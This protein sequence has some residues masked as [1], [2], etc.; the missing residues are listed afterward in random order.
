MLKKIVDYKRFELESRR[1]LVPYFELEKRTKGL[2]PGGSS[3]SRALVAP[4]VSI[5]AEIKYKSPSH[6]PFSCRM[7]PELIAE[8]YLRAGASAISVLTDE[9]FFSGKLDFL[10]RVRKHLDVIDQEEEI[11]VLRK[12]FIFDRYQVLEASLVGASALLLI[13]AIL[14]P[15]ELRSLLSF[16]R[17]KGLEVLVEVHSP[18]E[19]EI[20]LESGAEIIGVNNRNLETFEVDLRTSF[21]IARRLEGVK[22]QV[23]VAESGIS[24]AVQLSE[25]SDAGFD[26]FLVGSAFMDS[27]RPGEALAKLLSGL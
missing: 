19:L 27:P 12:D 10:A 4:G 1:N 5:I 2:R 15:S 25:L 13:V 6:G 20:A 9:H 21:D 7:D 8:A 22:G 3:L 17:D 26:G 23:L 11:P 14:S 18:R 24:E 16:S